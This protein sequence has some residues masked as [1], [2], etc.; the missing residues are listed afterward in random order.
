LATPYAPG[1][2]RGVAGDGTARISVSSFEKTAMRPNTGNRLRSP[3]KT[4]R[5]RFLETDVTE[6]ER[7]AILEYCLDH[8]I[9]VSQFLADLIFEDA[10]TSNSH[11]DPVVLKV[12]FRLTAEQYDKLDL[13]ASLRKKASVEE[14]IQELILPYLDMQ[15]FHTSSETKSMRF[16]LSEKEHKKALKYIADRGMPARKYVSFLA[17]KKIRKEQ[18]NRK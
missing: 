7:E 8:K 15:R 1:S 16:Y 13:L 2:L 12:E 3:A 9:S 18:E 17:M 6:E 10:A 5:V 14:L 11:R 4:P